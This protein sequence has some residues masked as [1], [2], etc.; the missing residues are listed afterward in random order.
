MVRD[1][2]DYLFSNSRRVGPLS[3]RTVIVRPSLLRAFVNSPIRRSFRRAFLRLREKFVTI[4]QQEDGAILILVAVSL[5]IILALLGLAVD[6][7][8]FQ[9]VKRTLQNA[10]DAAALAAA[11]EMR[12]CGNNSPNCQAMQTAAQSAMVENGITPTTVL[13]NCTG[14]PGSGVTLTLNSPAC[15]V[16]GDP[17]SGK[18]NYVEAIV[19][20]P[21][22]TFFASL[23]G[24]RTVNIETRAEAVHGL[25]GPCIYAL[26]PHGPAIT[27]LAGVIVRSNCGVVDESA[28][29][30]ALSCV[31]GAFL[32][33]PSIQV[34][35]GSEGLL[36]LATSTPR[37]NVPAPTPRDPLAYLPA[38]STANDPC[39][40]STGSPYSGSS[41]AVNII[42]GNVMLNPGIYCGG[43]SMT[44]SILSN[45]TFN[46]GTYILRDGP[47]LLGLTQGGLNLT[48]NT[49][50]SINGDGV[51]FYNEG[52]VGSIS[53]V[54]PAA[55]GPILSL[56]NIDLTAPSSGEY[57]GVLFYQAPGV[58]A[59]AT[60]IADLDQTSN[61]QGAIYLPNGSVNYAVSAISSSYNILVAYD[62]TLT[63][64]VLSQFGND[65][66]TL[67][68]GSPLNGDS[69]SLVQ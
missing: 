5:I 46:P 6:V 8:H 17:N 13:T 29:K 61:L 50:S 49:L 9:Q 48:L 63:A 56:A 58:T 21:V 35:G 10:A 36:C 7:G 43:I 22:Q 2:G 20:E 37:T 57:G 15:A 34:S 28:S 31:V 45:I 47:G 41:S 62:I 38:P 60:F 67:E 18:S 12:I 68:N 14:T 65:Y 39:G 11:T 51:L 27:I 53:V 23:V 44:A 64:Q 3:A 54:E 19:S 24:I 69:S 59:P 52:P 40:T 16:T 42:G 55:G 32:Y 66:S 25:G 30:D 26:D 33:A 4:P 1:R